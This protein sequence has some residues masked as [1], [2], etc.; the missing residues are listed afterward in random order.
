MSGYRR[1][2]LPTT[3][4]SVLMTYILA[5]CLYPKWQ[6]ALQ[7]EIDAVTGDRRPETSDAPRLPIL[8]AVIKETIRW[9]PVIPSSMLHTLEFCGQCAVL[10]IM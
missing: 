5:M 2:K 3:T 10:M 1:T 9:R 8:R 6:T 4:A 7:Q